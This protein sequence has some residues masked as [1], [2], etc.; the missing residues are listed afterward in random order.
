[1]SEV[2]EAFRAAGPIGVGLVYFVAAC[3]VAEFVVV[4]RRRFG[5]YQLKLI[6]LIWVCTSA[7]SLLFLLLA[8]R[9]NQLSGHIELLEERSATI[10]RATE[11]HLVRASEQCAA[12]AWPTSAKSIVDDLRRRHSLPA[13][14]PG[15]PRTDGPISS[16]CWS[17]SQVAYAFLGFFAEGNAVWQLPPSRS[18]TQEF[19]AAAAETARFATQEG[20]AERMRIPIRPDDDLSREARGHYTGL[21]NEV[22]SHK[23]E[24]DRAASER[25]WIH[26][27]QRLGHGWVY[28]FA[29][30][31]A[32]RLAKS[33]LDLL[34]VRSPQPPQTS[35][36][37]TVTM[38]P[39]AE[40]A[41]A[42]EPEVPQPGVAHTEVAPNGSSTRST[43]V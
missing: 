7:V 35:P 39:P 9:E 15:T 37:T 31:L 21:M 30:A 5:E 19:A 11:S 8:L 13:E 38:P 43:S 2:A 42:P 14:R 32:F 29:T 33:R 4:R 34:T 12:G 1:M 22:L 24:A 27:S 20:Y 3:A 6:D 26:A 40:A 23:Q 16:A 10:R 18:R 41:P 36:A 25:T 17:V 28:I